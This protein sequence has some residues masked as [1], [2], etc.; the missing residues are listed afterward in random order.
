MQIALGNFLFEDRTKSFAEHEAVV[1]TSFIRDPMRELV[2]ILISSDQLVGQFSQIVHGSR[3]IK[4]INRE[5]APWIPGLQPE[6][7][8]IFVAES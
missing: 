4:A 3:K 2:S 1:F 5:V 7:A 8:E 6:L